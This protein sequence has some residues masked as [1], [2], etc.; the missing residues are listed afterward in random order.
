MRFILAVL[1]F[2]LIAVA[3]AAKYDDCTMCTALVGAVEE[4]IESDSGEDDLEDL[5]IG[6]CDDLFVNDRMMKR[7][8]EAAAIK[9]IPM[10]MDLLSNDFPAE[11]VCEM[12]RLCDE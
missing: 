6:I 12:L 2:C 7:T 11:R 3:A 5:A 4:V 1:L 10:I 8:C 9:Y